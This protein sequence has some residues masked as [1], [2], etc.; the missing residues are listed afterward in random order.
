MVKKQIIKIPKKDKSS[1][2]LD[3]LLE[4]LYDAVSKAQRNI[5]ANIINELDIYFPYN[6][7]SGVRE[8]KCMQIAIP[9]H[10]GK[11]SI[12]DV[13]L[14]SL[15]HHAPL[16]IDTFTIKFKINMNEAKKIENTYNDNVENLED[17]NYHISTN[18]FG[19]ANK[20]TAEIE[21][22]CKIADTPEGLE[23]ISDQLNRLIE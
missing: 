14:F 9:D 20:N 4:A 2:S 11:H 10:H 19:G 17:R 8:A 21:L 23:K 12:I 18:M 5:R 3:I 15:V 7:E 13:T 1:N 22:K 6:E 16:N